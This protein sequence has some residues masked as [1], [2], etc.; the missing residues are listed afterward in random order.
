MR[1]HYYLFTLIFIKE[2]L[3]I[4]KFLIFLKLTD[5]FHISFIN[6]FFRLD[7]N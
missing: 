5:R 3:I 2:I 7:Q 6:N 4:F 1:I